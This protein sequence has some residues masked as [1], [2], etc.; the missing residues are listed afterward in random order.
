MYFENLQYLYLIPLAV[1]PL[2]IYLIFRKKPK[3]LVFSS[4]FLL[5]NL[6]KNVNRRTKIKDIILLIVRTILILSVILIF[7]GPFLGD[8][9]DFDPGKRTSAVFYLDTSSSMADESAGTTKFDAAR[10]ILIRSINGV[11]E[12]TTAFILTSDPGEKFKGN[13]KDALKFLNSVN[14]YGR[15]RPLK[16]ITGFADSLFNDISNTNKILLLLTDGLVDAG[17]NISFETSY[18]RHALLFTSDESRKADMSVDSVIISNRTFLRISLTSAAGKQTR[19]ELYQDGRKIYAQE[20]VFGSERYKMV[21]VEL[22][23]IGNAG[24]AVTVEV[25]DESSNL[26]N[27][28]YNFTIN[29]LEKKKML[30]IG[31]KDSR[32]VKNILSL[33]DTNPDSVL[34]PQ[35]IDHEA[36]NSVKLSDFSLLFF[37][38][39]SNFSSFTASSVKNYVTEGGSAY[40][41]AGDKLN[42]NDYSANLVGSLGFPPVSGYEKFT[43]SYAGIRIEEMKHPIFSDVFSEGFTGANSVEIFNYY[44]VLN[45]NWT[46]LI[47]VAKN[48]LFLEKKLGRGS[49]LFLTTGLEKNNSNILENGISV[50]VV[51]NSLLYLAGSESDYN[52][53][54]TIGDTVESDSYFYL[55][56]PGKSLDKAHDELSKKFFLKSPGFYRAY[57][58]EGVFLKQTAVNYE[59]EKF[60]DNTEMIKENFSSKIINYN[61]YSDTDLI[62]FESRDLKD[63]LLILILTL[64]CAEILIVRLVK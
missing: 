56:K 37:S 40:F 45:R 48:P 33:I 8:R 20:I 62:S 34:L 16:E 15:E 60:E 58:D 7:A 9:T 63:H 23:D 6:S 4:L 50:P 36:V 21:N 30:L 12:N 1:L 39:I 57:S 28:S 61:D 19:L 31:D 11:P 3:K 29:D 35:V 53:S 2:L 43:D 13:K 51:L 49:I 55:T 38:S 52:A 22:K 25:N 64:L 10:N 32:A 59:R 42:L 54:K 26:L 41:S 5:K 14:I 44:K 17:E 27:N 47:T 24:A 18:R 46:N